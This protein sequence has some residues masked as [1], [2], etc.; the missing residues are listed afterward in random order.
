MTAPSIAQIAA[1]TEKRAECP[2]YR[3]PSRYCRHC[4]KVTENRVEKSS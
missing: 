2:V 3:M 4:K 1:E